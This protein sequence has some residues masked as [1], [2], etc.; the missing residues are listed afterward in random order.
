M[1]IT[2]STAYSLITSSKAASKQEKLNDAIESFLITYKVKYH[3]K[4]AIH[5]RFTRMIASRP[6]N[7]YNDARSNGRMKFSMKRVWQ[8]THPQIYQMNHVLK[9]NEHFCLLKLPI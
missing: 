3:E 5:L 8:G 4:N 2:N 7:N 6:K 9:F 1:K